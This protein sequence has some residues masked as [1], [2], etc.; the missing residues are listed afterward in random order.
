VHL[1]ASDGT[2][3]P[4]Q[5]L[6]AERGTERLDAARHYPDLDEVDRLRVA[7]RAPEL[8]GMAVATL[9]AGRGAFRA[10][11]GA[12]ATGR[13]LGNE[14]LDAAL[15]RDGSIDLADRAGGERY[16]SLLRLELDGDV[17]DTYTREAPPGDRVVRSRGPARVRSLA[18]GPLVASLRGEWTLRGG[19]APEGRG[20]GE[21]ALALTAT[22]HDASPTLRLRLAW[23]NRATACRLRA[24][25]PTRLAG[26]PALAGTQFGTL[27]RPPLA[28]GSRPRR[29]R[30]TP[31]PTAPAHRFVAA[32]RGARGV[33]LLAPAFFEYEWTAAGDLLL[34]LFRSVEQLSRADLE[35]RPGHA[36][37]PAAT[38]LARELGSDAA[39][40]ALLPID[41][42]YLA[43]PERLLGAWEECFAPLEAQWLR[44]AVALA[45]APVGI[46][47]EGALVLSAIKPAEVG[48]GAVLRCWNPRGRTVRGAWTFAAPVARAERCRADETTVLAPIALED[49]GRRA[50]I[51][52]APF[53][54]ATVRVYLSP[55]A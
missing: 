23:D 10:R 5:R 24:R 15:R 29:G 12:H 32:A 46:E 54:A 50:P 30:E 19:R 6:A 22:V 2:R 27:A 33:A 21:I 37:W 48:G 49:G 42:S 25:I 35:A 18:G 9:G 43:S 51:E 4:L 39:E 1:V 17:G 3:I 36:A 45:P 55:T 13:A 11:G 20:A 14:R 53:D 47:L 7:F 41:E 16:G 31:A 34:T 40:L 52:V 26:V 8:A 38:P 44:D 28:S